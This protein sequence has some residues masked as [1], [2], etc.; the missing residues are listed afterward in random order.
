M[1]QCQEKNKHQSASMWVAH[2]EVEAHKATNTIINAGCTITEYKVR[3]SSSIV[4]PSWEFTVTPDWPTTDVVYCIVVPPAFSNANFSCCHIS[5]LS[6]T[7]GWHRQSF[8]RRPGATKSNPQWHS[9]TRKE[10]NYCTLK[11]QYKITASTTPL[12]LE[13]WSI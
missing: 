12:L 4:H 6:T 10:A 5:T 9:K 1:V 2:F 8:W 3:M 11:K 7:V 13:M